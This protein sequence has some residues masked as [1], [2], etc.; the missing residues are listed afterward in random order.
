MM[1]CTVGDTECDDYE[2]NPVHRVTIQALY[3]DKT[4]VTVRA[5]QACYNAG[6]CSTPKTTLF[7]EDCSWG[8]KERH[9]YP[10]NCVDWY[11]AKAYC[12]W[13]GKR[14]PSEA[15]WEYAARGGHNDWR[16]PWGNEPADSSRA[17]MGKSE[18]VGSKPAYGYGLYDMA[19]NVCEW[20]EDCWHKNY[21][22]A[23]KDGKPWVTKNCKSRVLRGECDLDESRV[24][25]V[26]LIWGEGPSVQQY[27]L[28]FRCAKSVD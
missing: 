18:P 26:S 9:D 3:M 6:K 14:L 5:Y 13:A 23:P 12:D 15:E 19:G 2:E 28:G 25:R 16:Y 7:T 11:Q 1:G 8:Y 21:E 4:E 27:Y 22:G 17:V 10:I 20:V 24:L